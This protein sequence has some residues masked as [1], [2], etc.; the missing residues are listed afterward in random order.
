MKRLVLGFCAIGVAF[1]I[2]G[3]SGCQA[4]EAAKNNVV[5]GVKGMGL[6]SDIENKCAEYEKSKDASGLR[7]YLIGLQKTDPKPEGWSESVD[8]LIKTWLA[9]AETLAGTILKDEIEKKCAD[10]ETK[11]D[12]KGLKTYLLQL[13]SAKKSTFG[14]NAALDELVTTWLVKAQTMLLKA[15]IAAKYQDLMAKKDV[16]G[17]SA[18]LSGLL[19]A[20]QKPTGWDSTI[21]SYVRSLFDGL[22]GEILKCRCEEIWQQVK[23]ALDERNFATARQLTSTAEPYAE[24]ELRLDILTYRV[25]LLNEVVNPY[26]S[27]V[28]IDEMQIKFRSLKDAGQVDQAKAFLAT[29]EPIKDSFPSIEQK[30]TEIA[31]SLRGLYWLDNRV[32][33][34]LQKH[35]A[36][37]QP[38]MDARSVSGEYRDYKAVYDLVDAAV[39]EMKLYNPRWDKKTGKFLKDSAEASW[40]ASMRN[41][42][43]V[44][45]TSEA[46]SAI[47]GAKAKLLDTI[48]K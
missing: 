29:V 39:A 44:M 34:Y 24:E 8:E 2:V 28:I 23:A 48:Q 35:I 41:V 17:A 36:E 32:N 25:G 20:K 18:Y 13:Q 19:S 47:E 4:L 3:V 14:W 38:I 30:V 1:G 15:E 31:P 27:D 43:C 11:N 12:A 42:R 45:T 5:S 6:K 9:K 22:K 7:S 46:N 37:I 10:F 33:E 40:E 26:Q 16:D 21:E